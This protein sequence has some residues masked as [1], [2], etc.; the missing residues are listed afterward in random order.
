MGGYFPICQAMES[1]MVSV[2]KGHL[3][4]VSMAHDWRAAKLELSLVDDSE[5]KATDHH[6]SR[7]FQRIRG[8]TMIYHTAVYLPSLY[9]QVLRARTTFRTAK[10]NP[11]S[12]A[13]VAKHRTRR[14][15]LYR[16]NNV[17]NETMAKLTSV[18]LVFLLINS[19]LLIS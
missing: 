9:K 7:P 8:E 12:P 13:T 14:E 4:S 6:S 5:K 1:V 19:W 10:K 2:F 18:C 11:L 15:T 17:P 16:N 3:G